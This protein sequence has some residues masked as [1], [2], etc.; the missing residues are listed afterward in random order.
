MDNSPIYQA[1]AYREELAKQTAGFFPFPEEHNNKRWK[2][3]FKSFMSSKPE[4]IQ[5]NLTQKQAERKSTALN[6]I[7]GGK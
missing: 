4:T 1:I 5:G 3:C 7:I 2:V 6:S